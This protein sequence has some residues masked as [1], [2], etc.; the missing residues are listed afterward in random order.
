M[1][2]LPTR[3]ESTLSKTTLELLEPTRVGGRIADVYLQFANS[4]TALSAYLNMEESLRQG[5]LSNQ[6]LEAIKLAVSEIT[7]CDYCLSVHSMKAA[8]AG[9][10]AEMQ[11]NIRTGQK[12]ADEQINI[13][14]DIVR[15]FFNKPG[16][17][18]DHLI[19]RARS[20]GLTDAALVDI[21][22]AVATIIFTN[23]T[24]HINNT[25]LSL[26][27]AAPRPQ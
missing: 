15:S 26:P 8:K 4:E 16:P 23:I 12:T 13:I 25:E 24:N 5:A 19:E 9:L 21:S 10:N 20:L 7:A 27:A 22:M 14:L 17:I 3:E 6:Q 2:R 11:L 18:D 1:A